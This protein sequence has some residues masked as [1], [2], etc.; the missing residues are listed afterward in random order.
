MP[1]VE[2]ESA[3]RNAQDPQ[4]ADAPDADQDLLP[5][6]GLEIAAVEETRDLPILLFNR[7]APP[8]PIRRWTVRQGRHHRARP[9]ERPESG[10]IL[11]DDLVVGLL[12]PSASTSWRKYPERY[13]RPIPTMGTPRSEADF[14]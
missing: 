1:L 7:R 11:E 6:A 12:R 2:M 14:R 4:R 13:A 8:A 3:G 10:Q 5:D 9:P